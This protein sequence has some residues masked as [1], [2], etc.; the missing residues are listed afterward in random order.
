MHGLKVLNQLR[1]RH[2]AWVK[3]VEKS[4][5]ACLGFP[6]IYKGHI[7]QEILIGYFRPK[8]GAQGTEATFSTSD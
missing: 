1:L 5:N 8:K 4:H 3:E 6:L 7:C 2:I